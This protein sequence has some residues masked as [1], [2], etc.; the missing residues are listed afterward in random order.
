MRHGPARFP[1]AA[2][3][4]LLGTLLLTGRAS[5]AV[6][7]AGTPLEL[8]N[9]LNVAVGGD[10]IVL[11]AGVTYTGNFLLPVHAGAGYVTIRTSVAD[12]MLPPP[13]TR[14]GPAAAPLLPKIRSANSTPALR[15][16]A[17][18]A[19][20]RIQ[21]VEFAANARGSGDI[22]QLGDGSAVQNTL[23]VVPQHLTLQSVY[24]HGD[25]LVG[26][27]RGIALNSGDTTI[28]DSYV[29][30]I[31]GVGIDTQAIGGWNGP[32]PYHILNNYLEAAGEVVM[33]GGDDPKI[34]NLV[35]SD[36]EVRGN[37]LSR[38]VSWRD[39]I[40]RG[41]TNVVAAPAAG[42]LPAGAYAY[43]VVARRPADSSSM[44][45]SAA[46]T[47]VAVTLSD[48]GG[49]LVQWAAVPDATEYRV[50]GRT[51]GA[52]DR[53][54]TVAA[55]ALSFVDTG[56]TGTSGTPGA[57]TVWIVKNLLELKNARRVQIDHNLLE[58]N[59]LQAQSGIA[60]VLTPRNQGGT[61]PWCV[62]EQV[63]FEYNIVRSVAAGVSIL[64]WDNLHPSQQANT[65]TIRHN[66]F[67]DVS[68]AW[69]GTGYFLYPMDN[70]R[71]VVVDHNTFIS[72]DGYGVVN[73]SGTPTTGF[74]FTNNVARHNSYGII[75]SGYGV[76]ASSIAYYF[77]GAV[78]AGNVFAGGKAS[79]YPA[80]N[81]FPTTS[82]FEAQFV[83]YGAGDFALTPSSAWRNAGTDGADLGAALDS[84]DP[85][86]LGIDA[87]ALAGGT[88]GQAYAGSLTAQGGTKP[89]AW[90]IASGALPA[91]LS[92]DS[93][94]GAISGVP[95][96]SGT[97]AFVARVVDAAGTRADQALSITIAQSVNHAPVATNA[98]VQAVEETSVSITLTAADPDGDALVYAMDALPQHGVLSGTAPRLAY[99]GQ[100]NF[101]GSDSFTFI[102]TDARGAASTGVVSINVANV[103]DLPVT[104]SQS[105]TASQNTAL[106]I[107]LAAQD[108]DG[109]SLT[110]AVGQPQHGSLSGTAPQLTYV[111]AAGFAGTDAFSF[112]VSDGAGTATGTVT[113]TVAA[114]A[115]QPLAIT[116]TSLADAKTGRGYSQT[117]AAT[118]GVAPY[119][120]SV[121]S[122]Q[123]PTGMSLDTATGVLSGKPASAGM[124]AFAVQ[125]ADGSGQTDVQ[126][127]TL[128][129][130][131]VGKK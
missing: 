107:T 50:Y 48:A 32:G 59:W 123:L 79:L 78:I 128:K 13:G 91:G 54:W 120:W 55:P 21:Y 104:A 129:V 38:P 96:S 99:S 16:A 126:A 43:K 42:T 70:P 46:S 101:F 72:P 8:Q 124:F 97:T 89:Y 3:W 125:V 69:G 100:V 122:G 10:T 95:S 22:I 41:P 56:G 49:V 47:E 60:V 113:I 5:A 84:T 2:L 130:I 83:N 51:P 53:Y 34:P 65:I 73:A 24:V 57:A 4:C 30:D 11:Q 82:D 92:L 119:R 90:S 37:T 58:H 1:G 40:L 86:P 114:A 127:L 62:V 68:R 108:A 64:G 102:V 6:I 111:P 29:S 77:P 67:S 23:A 45:S 103:N 71:D 106:A 76:G 74:V 98:T 131:A 112:S 117:L 19:Y 31:K 94:S 80:G 88:A 35:P 39:P 15:T 14:I 17:G 27:K 85:A 116:T 121:S 52:P 109:D 105:V 36:V 7:T 25:P 81:L 66:E 9:A 63:T 12:G 93:T 33:L 87:S 20:W 118:G 75:G 61:C 18:A 44:A 26:Q 110:W 115:A 28:A